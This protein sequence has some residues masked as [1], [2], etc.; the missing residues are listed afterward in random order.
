MACVKNN[1]F[2]RPRFGM[3]PLPPWRGPEQLLH[4]GPWGMKFDQF[5]SKYWR[6]SSKVL[7][8]VDEI[9]GYINWSETQ[10]HEPI[11]Y[12]SPADLPTRYVSFCNLNTTA[13]LRLVFL[14]DT[15]GKHRSI[16]VPNGDILI[17]CGDI[18]LRYGFSNS[19]GGGGIGG[20]GRLGL[21]EFDA[22]LRTLPHKMKIV[23]GGN[24][25]AA[26]EEKR[27]NTGVSKW[28]PKNAIF[29]HG[30]AV[31]IPV[32]LN[33]NNSDTF[34]AKKKRSF[35]TNVTIFGTPVSPPGVTICN[36]FQ[37]TALS[38]ST[39]KA[40]S[41]FPIMDN[42]QSDSASRQIDIFVSH[43]RNHYF[44]PLVF[45]RTI[46]TG[47]TITPR[48]WAYGHFHDKHGINRER[49]QSMIPQGSGATTNRYTSEEIIVE[50]SC[51]CINAAICDMIYRPVQP[52]VVVDFVVPIR[53]LETII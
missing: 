38:E 31:S 43:A 23:V 42:K 53:E 11:L 10:L 34:S 4:I 3:L 2:Q 47:G 16:S 14:S 48:I 9:P 15:H 44:E 20:E 13:T 18:L 51:L 45:P 7:Y 30:T 49:Y 5:L 28:N 12:E 19:S 27:G 52:T 6:L 46:M 41:Q 33:C 24:H 39:Q 1:L 40:I 50:K 17:H 36:A 29:L 8:I 26:L 25:D 21:D 37:D 32:E 35:S 22:W